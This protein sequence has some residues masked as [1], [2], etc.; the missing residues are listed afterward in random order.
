[1]GM[2]SIDPAGEGLALGLPADPEVIV[3]LA[4]DG[5]VVVGDDVAHRSPAARRCAHPGHR[6]R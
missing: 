3:E 1:M 6:R 2:I 5:G 4:V